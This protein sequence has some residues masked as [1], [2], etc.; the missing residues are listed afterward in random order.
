[1]GYAGDFGPGFP[2]NVGGSSGGARWAR[3]R[4]CRSRRSAKA[5]FLVCERVSSQ[6]TDTLVS[7]CV[8]LT[9]ESVVLRFC[10]PRPVPR[11]HSIRHSDRN[12][13]SG[14]S[15]NRFLASRSMPLGSVRG[16]S[17]RGLSHALVCRNSLRIWQTYLSVSTLA[18]AAP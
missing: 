12:S 4:L 9:A 8:T 16:G 14:S 1:M 11:K 2:R 7:R 13:G 5:R 3:A 18:P 10:P 15:S 6:T 17:R